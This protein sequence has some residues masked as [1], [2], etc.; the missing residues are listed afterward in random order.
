MAFPSQSRFAVNAFAL[1]LLDQQQALS[2]YL[3]LLLSSYKNFWNRDNLVNNQLCNHLLDQ[4]QSSKCYQTFLHHF[5]LVDWKSLVHLL[6]YSPLISTLKINAGCTS[7]K[8]Y[9][10]N[11]SCNLYNQHYFQMMKQ[12][13]FLLLENSNQLSNLNI[14]F[15]PVSLLLIDIYS[16]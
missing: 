7:Y 2:V 10:L 11:I 8:R 15:I 13:V 1:L 12:K 6:H 5:L 14:G 3:N 16:S 9:Y 4:L